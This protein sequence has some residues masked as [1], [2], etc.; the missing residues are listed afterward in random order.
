MSTIYFRNEGEQAHEPV[1]D[2][3]PFPVTL[4]QAA[5]VAV[6]GRTKKFGPFIY[7]TGANSAYAATD[8]M[9]GQFILNDVPTSGIIQGVRLLDADDDT[10]TCTIH[11]FSSDFTATADNS[12]LAI[13]DDDFRKLEASIIVDT[14]RDA[15]ISKIGIE[16]NLGIPYTA[17][18]GKLYGQVQLQT[19]TPTIA[20]G[21][22]EY[23]TIYIL[24]DANS[25]AI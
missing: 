17:P 25:E 23:L 6:G 24:P 15:V 20:S 10:F 7:L 9:G 18:E 11:L 16:D 5:P 14:F 4:V 21:V 22:N 12:P 3:H 8:A 1:S 19:G 13:T 2:L